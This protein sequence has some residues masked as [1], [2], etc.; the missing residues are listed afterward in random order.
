[1]NSYLQKQVE[2]F[3][4]FLEERFRA[5]IDFDKYYLAYSGGKDSHFLLWFIR[6]YLNDEK[7]KIVGVNTS[8]EIPEIR[9]RI[10]KNC[11]VILHPAKSRW[12]I[13]AQYGIPCF[14]KQQEEYI[15]RYQ[16]GSRSENTMNA[17]MGK[18]RLFVLNKLARELLLSG[19]LHRVSNK[20]CYYNKELPMTRYG[21]ASGRKAIIG[22]RQS[23]SKTRNAKYT[24]CLRTNGNFTPI[25]DFS[26]TLID[27][28]YEAYGIEIPRIYEAVSRTGCGGCPYSRNCRKELQYLPELQRQ[29]TIDYFRESYE[30]KG[31]S[32]ALLKI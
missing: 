16:R 22:V 21:R 30:V 24:S 20:C 32:H 23:E 15:Y 19:R 4:K 2:P 13:K 3:L 14:S 8:F 18:G 11:D 10:L 25:F 26:D 17:V 1:M 5:K 31:I 27:A 28:I 12:D 29:K 9:D 6:E 7:I